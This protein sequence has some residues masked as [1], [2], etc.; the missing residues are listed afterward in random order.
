M[1]KGGGAPCPLLREGS[2][3]VN[4]GAIPGIGKEWSKSMRF[5]I[6][7]G[8]IRQVYLCEGLCARGHEAALFGFLLREDVRGAP[9]L[10]AGVEAALAGADCVLLPYPCENGR[11]KVSAPF[12]ETE[13]GILALFDLLEGRGV[14]VFAGKVGPEVRAEAEKRNILIVDYS[15]REDF[16]IRNAIPSAEGA[17]QLAM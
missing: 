3:G 1:D 5:A 11:L 12:S 9:E 4:R 8:D 10:K 16:I 14:P 13:I 2:C 17:L 6:I 15:E 7:G